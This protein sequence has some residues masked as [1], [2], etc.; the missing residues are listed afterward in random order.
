MNGK[1]RIEVR[2]H[3]KGGGKALHIVSAWTTENRLGERTGENGRKSN[4]TTVIPTLLA[5]LALEGL[6]FSVPSDKNRHIQFHSVSTHDQKHGRIEDR[7][8]AV[9][10]EVGWL[11]EGHLEYRGGRI[12]QRLRGEPTVERRL[13]VSSMAADAEAFT[14]ADIEG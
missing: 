9:S 10:E 3:F 2:G 11:I 4:E 13:F 12:E 1:L 6:D 14:R 5:K 7:D 8:Y